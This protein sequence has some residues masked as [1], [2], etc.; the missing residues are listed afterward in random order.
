MKVL[1]E[2]EQ[3]IAFDNAGKNWNEY[4]IDPQANITEFDLIRAENDEHV[5][6][7]ESKRWYEYGTQTWKTQL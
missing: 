6:I 1:P 4:I 3:Q 2:I 5:R 7:L